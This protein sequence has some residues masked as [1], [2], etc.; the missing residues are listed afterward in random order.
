[1]S[2][3][4]APHDFSQNQSIQMNNTLNHKDNNICLKQSIQ[5]TTL[6]VALS[7]EDHHQAYQNIQTLNILNIL[8]DK[9]QAI[10]EKQ[11]AIK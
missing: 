1:M 9:R 10:K 6:S 5:A 8:I 3:K 7:P 2:G 4:E 11:Q